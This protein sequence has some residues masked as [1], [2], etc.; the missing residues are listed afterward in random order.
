MNT[1]KIETGLF[2]MDFTTGH[3]VKM[4]PTNFDIKRGQHLY[5]AGENMIGQHFAALDDSQ[6]VEINEFG[7]E[8]DNLYYS[9][10]TCYD[11]KYIK[12]LSQI[13][14]IGIYYVED[15][16]LYTEE[17][18]QKGLER[19]ARIAKR[20][21][22]EKQEAKRKSEENKKD[23]LK[24]YSFLSILNNSSLIYSEKEAAKNVRKLLAFHF[25][26][27]KF[28][29]SKNS[30]SYTCRWI[31]GPTTTEVNEKVISLFR[32]GR[33]DAYTDYAYT[34]ETDFNSLFGGIEY[35]HVSRTYSEEIKMQ[36]RTDLEKRKGNLTDLEFDE[37][38]NKTLRETDFTPKGAKGE[39]QPV[40]SNT[41]A[42]EGVELVEYSAKAFA[43]FGNTKSIK[44][45]LKALGGR[46]NGRLKRGAEI[47]PG[48]IFSKKREIELKALCGC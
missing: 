13:K 22:E 27:V 29:V 9:P 42:A 25:P 36:I 38:F 21:E 15:S 1:N 17:Q 32:I 37:I 41:A 47:A 5:A 16:P 6:M 33:F 2:E 8:N 40:Q 35:I 23:L 48:W 20:K 10:L 46:F 45:Q 28:S 3:L 7:V 34:E 18:I 30:G 31:D 11:S 43:V 14:G 19:A 39:A 24:K 12:P 26:N 44:E 4:Q